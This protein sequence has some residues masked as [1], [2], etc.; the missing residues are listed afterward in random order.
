MKIIRR[1]YKL[2]PSCMEKHNVSVVQAE[3]CVEYK[4]IV[5]NFI[6]T[7]EHCPR[8]D[9]YFENEDMMRANKMAL[10]DAYQKK[11]IDGG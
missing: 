7:Y 3:E 1:E 11:T 6:A 5:V 8:T 9:E 10:I 4:N 2:C